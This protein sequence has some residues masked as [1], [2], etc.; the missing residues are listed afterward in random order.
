MLIPRIQALKA[1]ANAIFAVGMIS[2][3]YG[4]LGEQWLVLGLG[5]AVSFFSL[6]F[7]HYVLI[8][9]GDNTAEM[10]I[11]KERP[12]SRIPAKPLSPNQIMTVY[13]SILEAMRTKPAQEKELSEKTGLQAEQLDAA[14]GV[15]KEQGLIDISYSP[16][17]A[18]IRRGK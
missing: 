7:L 2:F 17:G 6:Y 13:D 16:F 11:Q 5:L 3:V 8:H 1:V 12:E 4:F 14:L 15:L 9:Y 10:V 18:T